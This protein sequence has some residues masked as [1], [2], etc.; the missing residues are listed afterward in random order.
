MSLRTHDRAIY[1]N[2]F[3][4]M[5]IPGLLRQL[6][7]D[8]PAAQYP[9]LNFRRQLSLNLPITS[10]VRT[11]DST[12][13][14]W[15]KIAAMTYAKIM[16]HYAREQPPSRYVRPTLISWR[17]NQTPAKLKLNAVSAQSRDQ[18]PPCLTILYTP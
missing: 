1:C 12:F 6:M 10:L 14:P 7:L 11:A 9:I 16:E 15:H 8:T 13:W 3:P 2:V 17:L 18:Y 4:P 5:D